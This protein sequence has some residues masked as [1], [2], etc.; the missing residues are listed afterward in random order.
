MGTWLIAFGAGW[1]S[2]WS[3]RFF[4]YFLSKSA[5]GLKRANLRLLA[6]VIG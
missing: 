2:R 4:G 1:I 5:S 3:P 6:E